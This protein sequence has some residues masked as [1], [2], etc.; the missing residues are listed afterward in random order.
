MKLFESRIDI[1]VG[2]YPLL[3]T[4]A[5]P[6]KPTVFERMIVFLVDR[7][8]ESEIKNSSLKEIFAEVLGLTDIDVFLDQALEE[9]TSASVNVLLLHNRSVP[10]RDIPIKAM[11]LTEEEGRQLVE[12]GQLPGFREQEEST[13]FYDYINQKISDK[14]DVH[15]K[16]NSAFPAIPIETFTNNSTMIPHDIFSDYL[17]ETKYK[18]KDVSIYDITCDQIRNNFKTVSVSIEVTDGI[19]QLKCSEYPETENYLNG[20]PV[21]MLQN[22]FFSRLFDAP[23]L[24]NK[25]N[26]F[27]PER[28]QSIQTPREFID[29]FPASSDFLV[30][31]RNGIRNQIPT[32]IN[33]VCHKGA[34][35]KVYFEHETGE[36]F[37][38]IDY[39]LPWEPNAFSDF[40]TVW[41]V[42]RFQF[43]FNRHLISLPLG[44]RYE[45]PA[46]MKQ[47]IIQK[48]FSQLCNSN[49]NAKYAFLIFAFSGDKTQREL[50]CNMLRQ[51]EDINFILHNIVSFF[52]N[53]EQKIDMESLIQDVFPY[54]SLNSL[55]EIKAFLDVIA[56]FSL[57]AK[58]RDAAKAEIV[59]I[60][61]KM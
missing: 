41:E 49:D 58:F 36:A 61:A 10:L 5:A 24:S 35:E 50:I 2:E 18:D 9:L 6:R 57:S 56:E 25:M 4:I 1:P 39:E 60:I 13:L 15:I 48:A 17:R 45:F 27:A 42:S 16:R 28:F 14:R 29:S 40:N 19:L 47:T 53:L 52:A 59:R 3:V 22:L 31:D 23:E 7:Y 38:V 46:E 20:I 37:V 26:T 11:E 33:F 34:S 32:T 51:E 54:E 8:N 12:T 21:D 30:Y 43:Q 44:V 55:Q